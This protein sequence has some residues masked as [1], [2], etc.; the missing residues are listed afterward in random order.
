MTVWSVAVG[1]CASKLLLGQTFFYPDIL[2]GGW[3]GKDV[4]YKVMAPWGGGGGSG[5][6]PPTKENFD[7]FFL[8]FF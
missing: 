5:G 3:G 8:F 6:M 4:A 2:T 1:V 7:V